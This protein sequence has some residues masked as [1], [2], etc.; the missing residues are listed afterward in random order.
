MQV[1]EFFTFIEIIT[2]YFPDLLNP[3]KVDLNPGKVDLNPK[4]C[5]KK[6]STGP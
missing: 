1:L 3:G 2:A 4:K 5:G 6:L